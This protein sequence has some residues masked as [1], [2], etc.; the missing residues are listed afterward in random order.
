ML[1]YDISSWTSPARVDIP[2]LSMSSLSLGFS[3]YQRV[4]V[5]DIARGSL[6]HEAELLANPNQRKWTSKAFCVR[7]RYNGRGGRI[8]R[9]SRTLLTSCKAMDVSAD[10]VAQRRSVFEAAHSG[11]WNPISRIANPTKPDQPPGRHRHRLGSRFP[12]CNGGSYRA[13]CSRVR[14]K[15][16]DVCSTH[17]SLNAQRC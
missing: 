2:K 14:C 17:G 3:A 1:L 4:R 16:F 11:G 7:G 12:V 5:T 8:E 15:K 6:R 9:T 10:A 13:P